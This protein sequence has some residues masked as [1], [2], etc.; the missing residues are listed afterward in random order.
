MKSESKAKPRRRRN[1]PFRSR[2]SSSSTS[3]STSKRKKPNFEEKPQQEV[4][5]S[6]IE[7]EPK[8]VEVLPKETGEESNKL[9]TISKQVV[10]DVDSKQRKTNQAM[11]IT[12]FSS[13]HSFG[14]RSLGIL[15]VCFGF[16]Y[17]FYVFVISYFC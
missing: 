16:V 8:E 17:I 4:E 7:E 15:V 11:K 12:S 14:L 2:S 9:S 5:Q 10:Q 3:T 6:V 1:A 13:M